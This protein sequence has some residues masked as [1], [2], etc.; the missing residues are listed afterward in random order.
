M[1]S[2]ALDSNNNII[3]TKNWQII[4]GIDSLRQDIQNR[5]AMFNKEY[6]FNIYDGIDYISL[7]SLNRK[8][9]LQNAITKE[10]LKDKRVKIVKVKNL[11][12]IKNQLVF[13]I[14]ITTHKD[15]VIYV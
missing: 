12:F 2:I 8:D 10:I 7:L 15:E 14:E 9:D 4:N 1:N 13:E 3:A 6:P 11:T 5:L